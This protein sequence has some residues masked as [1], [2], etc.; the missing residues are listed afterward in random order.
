[1]QNETTQSGAL[2]ELQRLETSTASAIEAIPHLQ[3]T[4]VRFAAAEFGIKP[5]RGRKR[6]APA[7]DPGHPIAP[8]PATESSSRI[9]IPLTSS[10]ACR[11]HTPLFSSARSETAETTL[12]SC[13]EP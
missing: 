6:P 2:G 13:G 10:G 1:M 5:L 3:P 4:R 7:P 11:M 9:I 12:S 8:P